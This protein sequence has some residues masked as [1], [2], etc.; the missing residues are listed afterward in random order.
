M[1]RSVELANDRR[2][3]DL[4]IEGIAKQQIKV[5]SATLFGAIRSSVESSVEK[6]LT[7]KYS[8]EY[9]S[10]VGVR[11]WGKK[12]NIIFGKDTILNILSAFENKCS[13]DVYSKSL[14]EAGRLSALTFFN[15]FLRLLNSSGKMIIPNNEIEFLSLLSDFDSK[16]AWWS[17]KIKLME[18]NDYISA[19]IIK[20]FTEY[21]NC[22]IG[23]RQKNPFIIGYISTLLN[24]CADYFRVVFRL[25]NLGSINRY[26]ITESNQIEEDIFGKIIIRLFFSKQYIDSWKLIDEE[27]F[28][29]TINAVFGNQEPTPDEIINYVEK[30]Q[31]ISRLI[32]KEFSKE[33]VGDE[34]QLADE[35]QIISRNPQESVYDL[36]KINCLLS[37]LRLTYEDLRREVLSKHTGQPG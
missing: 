5:D 37:N 10:E 34:Y 30:L 29:M 24:S 21:P 8:F 27:I 19:E 14:F 2:V 23:N 1:I 25:K 17:E 15:D 11:I 26:F 3:D 32:S 12:D 35:L 20:P 22:R 18:E 6:L 4:I 13:P 7:P 31:Q 33:R 16:T 9:V 36:Y 28:K